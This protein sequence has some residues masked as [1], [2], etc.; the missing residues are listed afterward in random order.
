MRVNTRAGATVDAIDLFCGFG[1]SSQ[2]IHAAGADLRLAANHNPLAVDVHATNFPDTDHLVA[3]MNNPDN[4][5]DHHGNPI[6][7]IDPI[8]LP[9]SR[10]LWASP[11]CRFH[12]PANATKLY[13]RPRGGTLFTELEEDFDHDLYARSERSRVTMI[14]PLRYA[15][16]HLPE[17][18]VIENVV[19]AAK[20]GPNRDGSTFRWWL[21]EWS[22]IGYDHTIC[23]FNSKFFPPTPQSRDRMYVVFWRKG[24]PTPD[25]DYRPTA[26]CTSDRCAGTQIEA[27]QSWKRP[28]AAWPVT[29][30][31]KHDRQYIYACPRCG[32][33]VNP[34]AWPAYTAIDWTDLGQRIADRQRPLADKTLERIQRGLNKFK[35]FP[36]VLVKAAG[37]TYERPGSHT[38]TRSPA[39]P[40]AAITQTLE[41]AIAATIIPPSAGKQPRA[42]SDQLPSIVTT[43]KPALATLPFL[44]EMRGGGSVQAGQHPVTDPMHTVTAGGL[45]HGFVSTIVGTHDHALNQ[46]NPTTDPLTTLTTRGHHALITSG[47]TL[48]ITHPNG[49]RTRHLTEPLQTLTASRELYAAFTKFNG[50]PADTAWHPFGDQLGAVTARDTT[51]MVTQPVDI[52]DV[53]FRMLKPDPE[54]RRAMAFA[55]DYQLLGNKTEMTAGLGNAVT[56]PVASWITERV[57]AILG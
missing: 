46:N 44:I 54:L 26:I 23:Y 25:L 18:V 42:A 50:G 2:G 30:W 22:N 24:N 56:P 10:F 49:D 40:M 7:Y 21:Q 31:G 39:D 37:H 35:D 27:I 14:C 52:A 38:R 43:T 20:W 12:S 16:K 11:S 41:W 19:E 13:E 32:Q 33:K 34:T 57:L 4:P 3:D 1:G 5:K 9:P 29:P 45:H 53:H 36:A 15:A 28:T 8:D 51:G 6:S 47:F 48:P 17:A 55:D